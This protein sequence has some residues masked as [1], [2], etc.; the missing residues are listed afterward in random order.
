MSKKTLR[1]GSRESRLA[2]IQTE[3]V[4][5]EIKRRNPD[6]EI[7]LVTMK[8]TGDKIL[9]RSLDKIGGKGL[10][11]KELD[12]ALLDGRIDL[13]VHS[14]KDMPMDTAEELPILAYVQRGDPRDCLVLPEGKTELEGDAPLG[15]SSYRRKLQL[16]SLYPDKKQKGI[17][18]NVITRLSKLDSGE[19]SG[20][21]L[22]CAGLQRLKLRERISRIFTID[23][24]LPAAGQ[25]VLAVQGRA[26]EKHP[27]LEEVNHPETE[28]ASRAERQFVRVLDGGCSSP[29]AAYALENGTQLLLRGLYW[30]EETGNCLIE[31][32]VGES[33][34]PEA[35]GEKLAKY[36]KQICEG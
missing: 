8:T 23:E 27:Y 16:R 3:I 28:A 12:R 5:Q 22:A 14:L 6:I 15:C 18:G 33:E 1:I 32:M 13:S 9:D 29:I 4:I 17:R 11:V 36:L 24:M 19:F 31:E 25:G 21:I 34:K 35:L 20:L 7:E 2:I 10:F 26:G 30:Q